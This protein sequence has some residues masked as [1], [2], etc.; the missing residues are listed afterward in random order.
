[1]KKLLFVFSLTMVSTVYAGDTEKSV[2]S[3]T[4]VV[5]EKTEKSAANNEQLKAESKKKCSYIV[6]EADL[7]LAET[8][9]PNK[10]V[11]ST[12]TRLFCELEA[13]G[14]GVSEERVRKLVEEIVIP[15]VGTQLMSQWVLGRNW[16]K[17]SREQ[18]IEFIKLFKELLV[19]TYAGS[20]SQ[21]IGMKITYM[22]FK[23]MTKS[24][25][26]TVK[27]SIARDGA[28]EVPLAFKLRRLKDG[29]WKVYDA[30][31][32]GISLVANYRTTFNSIIQKDG[33]DALFKKLKSGE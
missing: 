22:P 28:S 29:S 7:I 23:Q 24:R 18:K 30:L 14:E 27:L 11:R 12:I 17:L 19:R 13:E 32:D 8:D 26:A 4:V 2:D 15:S 3:K 31:V 10:V 20:L 9:E 33:V 1:M 5:A 6:D 21:Y 16:K 25:K